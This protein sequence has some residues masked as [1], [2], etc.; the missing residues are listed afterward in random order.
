MLVN[1]LKEL[2]HSIF[3]FN[4]VRESQNFKLKKYLCGKPI[5][6]TNI[7]CS[8]FHTCLVSSRHKLTSFFFGII[9][10]KLR[11]KKSCSLQLEK[12][13]LKNKSIFS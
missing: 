12:E 5:G 7:K 10:K 2:I 6:N 13:K 1:Q 3:F 8:L 11:V 9:N 4:Y